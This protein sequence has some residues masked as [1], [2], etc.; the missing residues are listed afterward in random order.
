[1]VDFDGIFSAV[2]PAKKNERR[3]DGRN[4]YTDIHYH[5]LQR[6]ACE[7]AIKT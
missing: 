3:T 6:S 4:C 1:M 7:R 2:F 5:P